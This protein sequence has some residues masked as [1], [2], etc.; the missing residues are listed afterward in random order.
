[1]IRSALRRLTW[2]HVAIV[3]MLLP[4]V[5]LL[6]HAYRRAPGTATITIDPALQYQTIRGWEATSEA[7]L[8][9]PISHAYAKELVD[10]AAAFGLTRLR[11]EVRASYENTRD[12]EREFR[13]GRITAKE[14]RCARYATV[15]DNNDSRVLAPAGFQFARLDAVIEQVVLPFKA[16][17]EQTGEKLWL[18]VQYVAFTNDICDGY[19][20]AHEDPKEYAEFVLAVYTHLRDKYSLTP[21]SWE[22]MLEPDNTRIWTAERMGDAMEQTAKRLQA[23]GFTP[24]FIAP[25]TTSAGN[26]VPFFEEIWDRKSLRPFLRELSYHRYAAASPEVIAAIGRFGREHQVDTAMLEMIG[27]GYEQ[28]H[29]DLTAGGVSTWQQYVLGFPERDTGAHYFIVDPNAAEGKRIQLSGSGHYLR[30]YFQAIRP[31]AHRIGVSTDHADFDAVAVRDRRGPV[32][33]VVKGARPGEVTIRRLPAG[34]YHVSCWTDVS[35]SDAPADRCERTATVDGSGTLVA[36]L[37]GIGVLSIV[38]EAAAAVR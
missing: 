19:Q 23:A 28:L 37:P 3:A 13:E 10:A 5:A 9:E 24:S 7:G 1:M 33:V 30:Q 15:N 8:D 18:N 26:A 12:I 29:E 25:S 11:V 34:T 38:G 14:W 35:R 31:G 16:R 4:P 22:T 36:T 17:L 21:D 20:Y 6:A 32:A 2:R 27:A